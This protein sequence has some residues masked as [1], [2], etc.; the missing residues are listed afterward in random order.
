M[1]KA[2]LLKPLDGDAE[3]ATR[4]FSRADFDTLERMGAVKEVAGEAGTDE[5]GPEPAPVFEVKPEETEALVS[6]DV[7]R[8][9]RSAN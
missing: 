4:E 2:I 9:R 6:R 3:G 8:R 1:I 7:S 5:P